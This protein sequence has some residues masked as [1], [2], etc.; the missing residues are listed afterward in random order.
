VFKKPDPKELVRKWQAD[1]RGE[2]RK[3]DRQIRGA[4]QTDRQT[5]RQAGRQAGRQTGRS[6][7]RAVKPRDRQ[8]YQQWD[9][10]GCLLRVL[11]CVD[12]GCSG[13]STCSICKGLINKNMSGSRQ[14]QTL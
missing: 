10:W 4:Q 6:E 11:E 13:S 3:I 9:M 8:A 12:N 7:A 2:Q 5:D 1:L 14:Q